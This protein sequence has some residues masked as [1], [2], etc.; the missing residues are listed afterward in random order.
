MAQPKLQTYG[1]AARAML[2]DIKRTTGATAKELD[3][4]LE[5][6]RER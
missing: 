6:L 4:H 5:Q 2:E 3:G 1:V